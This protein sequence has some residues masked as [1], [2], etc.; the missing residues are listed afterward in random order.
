MTTVAEGRSG[1]MAE[2]KQCPFCGRIPTVE[3][4]GTNRWF[5][6]CKCGIAQDKLYAQKCD[7]VRAW[8]RRKS[9]RH[10]IELVRC[11]DCHFFEQ[12]HAPIHDSISRQAAIDAV[13]KYA[14]YD[15]FDVSVVEED[16]AIIALKDLPSVQP[17]R[18]SDDETCDSCRY[19]DNELDEEPCDGCTPANSGYCPDRI[20][21]QPPISKREW[22]QMGYEA[23]Q[24]SVQ[25]QKGQ[26]EPLELQDEQVGTHIIK[27]CPTC[28]T[29]WRIPPTSEYLKIAKYPCCPCGQRIR[30]GGQDEID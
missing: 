20:E 30:W 22:Y 8:N 15:D 16:V 14:H 21:L 9:G 27:T 12:N 2:L 18:M 23:G 3:D 24:K 25:P 1:E 13:R 26:A 4:C 19:R 10:E 6:R 29:P 28:H 11:K 5:V 7:A 17:Q